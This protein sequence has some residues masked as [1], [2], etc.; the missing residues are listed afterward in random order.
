MNNK[1]LIGTLAGGVT[2]FFLGFMIYGLALAP[3]MA[4]NTNQ[5][6]AVAND[7]M[8]LGVLAFSNLLTSLLIALFIQSSSNLLQ[9]IGKGSLFGLLYAAGVNLNSYAMTTMYQNFG[10][11]LVDIAAFMV[12]STA[13]AATVYGV[14][15]KVK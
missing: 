10:V 1:L 9:A 4:A 13:T 5:C 8:N 15:R 3:F 11:L 14:M 6:L 12:L 7:Q 2:F